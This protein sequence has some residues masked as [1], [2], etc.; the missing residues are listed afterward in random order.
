M[1]SRWETFRHIQTDGQTDGR[2]D[3]AKKTHIHILTFRSEMCRLREHIS[4]PTESTKHFALPTY[5]VT[6]FVPFTDLAPLVTPTTW[7]QGQWETN[8]GGV[9]HHTKHYLCGHWTGHINTRA[10]TLG[11]T[12][13]GDR[14]SN[15]TLGSSPKMRG[16]ATWWRSSDDF[17]GQFSFPF[18]LAPNE[19]ISASMRFQKVTG[20]WVLMLARHGLLSISDY[21][22]AFFYF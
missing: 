18:G 9:K 19:K 17:G 12:H 1:S 13:H 7:G 14:W 3:I 16:G 4:P 10:W 8:V 2:N 20:C 6:F 22:H 15:G 5:F 11:R 21:I